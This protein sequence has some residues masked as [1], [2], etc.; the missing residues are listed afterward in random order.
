VHHNAN[1]TRREL[2]IAD[3]EAVAAAAIR[4]QRAFF[5]S[6]VDPGSVRGRSPSEIIGKSNEELGMPPENLATWTPE[7]R[8]AFAGESVRFSFTFPSPG[9]IRAF[10]A[11]LLPD[12]H[13]DGSVQSV[14]AVVMDV[15]EREREL[16]ERLE[17]LEA[18][19][20]ARGLLDSIIANAPLGICVLDRNFRY[21]LVNSEMAKINGMPPEAH[22]GRTPL[23]LLDLPAAELTRAREAALD[24]KTYA[25]ELAGCTPAAPGVTRNWQTYWFPV[26]V[27]GQTQGVGVIVQEITDRKRLE[28]ARDENDRF[29]EMFIGILG[30]DL[31]NPL[32]A[33]VT[34]AGILG[35]GTGDR[36]RRGANRALREP[37]GAHD[38]SDPRLHARASGRR[39]PCVPL[40]DG[41]SA[42]APACCRGSRTGTA[43]RGHRAD[44]IGTVRGAMG[45]RPPGP[46]LLEPDRKR[47]RPRRGLRRPRAIGRRQGRRARLGEQR[48]RA[49]S[50]RG[51]ASRLRSVSQRTTGTQPLRPRF[52]PLHL[53]RQLVQAHGGDIRVTSNDAEGTTFDVA[54]PTAGPL[55]ATE[56][57]GASDHERARLLPH[58]GSS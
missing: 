47:G 49:D 55:A 41:S 1:A 10:D 11:Q 36:A 20:E 29:R 50:R 33:I 45:R 14:L 58:V 8:R 15:T 17:T 2:W 5:S 38:R 22:Y 42:A 57:D 34:G 7:L 35:R 3:P 12:R 48:R 51:P 21:E 40:R 52:G 26:L 9:G 4:S 24:G 19:N 16:Q 25:A 13:V 27:A 31:R 54:L 32:S 39:H 43:R 23:E 44:R 28:F 53:A 6:H 46:G 30:H 56:D 18:A 37:D